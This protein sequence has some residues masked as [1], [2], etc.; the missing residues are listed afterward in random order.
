MLRRGFFFV[1]I[2]VFALSA[3]SGNMGPSS[4]QIKEPWA[5]AAS[6]LMGHGEMG[7]EPGSS[8]TS[9]NGAVYMLIE[10]QS[11]TTDKLVSVSSD[12]AQFVE[13]HKTE[14]QDGVMR[15]MQVEYIEVPAK[16]KAEL[17]P[18]G[19]H[20]M[21]IGLKKDLVAGETINLVLNF[22]LAGHIEVQAEVRA[23]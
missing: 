9:A 20:V 8:M 2:L 12:V 1:A 19:Y 23:P 18:G 13:V 22:E 15:M 7:K 10:N 16:G 17:K 5:R 14:M 21:L 4:I 6:A 11:N 3:C